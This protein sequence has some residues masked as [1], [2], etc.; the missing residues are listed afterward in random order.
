MAQP[1]I[2]DAILLATHSS[3]KEPN[4]EINLDIAQ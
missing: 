3:L 2:K 4:L 1:S